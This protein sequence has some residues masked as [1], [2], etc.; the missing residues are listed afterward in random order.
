MIL[1]SVVVVSFSFV[2]F[3]YSC[4]SYSSAASWALPK[5]SPTGRC[6]SEAAAA[7]AEHDRDDR[8][9][10]EWH[11]WQ[12]C[13]SLLP[14]GCVMIFATDVYQ[15]DKEEQGEKQPCDEGGFLQM[16]PKKWDWV[17]SG[18]VGQSCQTGRWAFALPLQNMIVSTFSLTKKLRVGVRGAEVSSCPRVSCGYSAVLALLCTGV[19]WQLLSNWSFSLSGD[20]ANILKILFSEY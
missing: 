15:W 2:F 1:W 18:A 10:G 4:L 12:Q 3:A 16:S 5:L 13:W 9:G 19:L 14:S 20:H 8:A 6:G 17:S 7:V 11:C